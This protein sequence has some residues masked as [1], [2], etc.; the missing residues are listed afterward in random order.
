MSAFILPI[1]GHAGMIIQHVFMTEQYKKN[2][3]TIMWDHIR[4]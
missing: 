1:T 2:P 3:N 4:V